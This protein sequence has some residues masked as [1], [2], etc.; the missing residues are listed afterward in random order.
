MTKKKVTLK[1]GNNQPIKHFSSGV[2]SWSFISDYWQNQEAI[3]HRLSFLIAATLNDDDNW[4]TGLSM[5]EDFIAEVIGK[6]EEVW[7]E[8]KAEKKE[9]GENDVSTV[10]DTSE[11]KFMAEEL[12]KHIS[13]SVERAKQEL[14]KIDA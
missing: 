12:V 3:L 11:R 4:Y 14:Q 10:K 5:L 1:G 9:A 8:A 2:I 13:G 7:E 6:H